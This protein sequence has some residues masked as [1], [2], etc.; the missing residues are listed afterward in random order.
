LLKQ[1]AY[2]FSRRNRGVGRRRFKTKKANIAMAKNLQ[3]SSYTHNNKD[4][5]AKVTIDV[6]YNPSAIM[7]RINASSVFSD[8]EF[9]RLSEYYQFYKIELI[10]FMF[11]AGTANGQVYVNYTNDL[12]VSIDNDFSRVVSYPMYKIKNIIFS[13]IKCRVDDTNGVFHFHGWNSTDVT[14]SGI[15]SFVIYNKQQINCNFKI[16][17]VV[18]FKG[19]EGESAI[20][21]KDIPILQ[22]EKKFADAETQV[23]IQSC[24]KENNVNLTEYGKAILKENKED[25]E[26]RKQSDKYFEHAFEVISNQFRHFEEL[27]AQNEN[28]VFIKESDY[29]KDFIINKYQDISKNI[30][31]LQEFLAYKS[32]SLDKELHKE[33][34]KGL[35]NKMSKYKFH[36]LY[37]KLLNN[38]DE[39]IYKLIDFIK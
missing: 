36:D 34:L 35:Q 24:K 23:E 14:P 7:Q 5:T 4:G 28:L 27:I 16:R 1:I 31:E 32:D 30:V 26:K 9:T 20:N 18:R 13:Q 6:D 8:P 33:K 3:R 10:N 17:Y 22:P 38:Q 15:G 11:F 39:K 37:C 19:Y 12:L 25:L 29:E 2:Q 21:V